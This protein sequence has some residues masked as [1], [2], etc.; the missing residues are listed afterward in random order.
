MQET[1]KRKQIN[2]KDAVEGSVILFIRSNH[3]TLTGQW[4]WDMQ[5][6]ALYGSDVMSFPPDFEGTKGIIHPD[7]LPHVCSALEL[8]SDSE[9]SRLDFRLITTY[10]DVK[11]ICGTNVSFGGPPDTPLPEEQS[12]GEQP[13]QQFALRREVDFLR[14]RHAIATTAEKWLR[15]GAWAINKS[16]AEVWY[17]DGIYHIH[18][19]A[20]QSLNAHAN[21]FHPFLHPDDRMAF[22]DAFE[23]AYKAEVPV[24]L[25]YRIV[26]PDLEI[27]TVRLLTHW[28]YNSKGH[29]VFTA[30]LQDK[31]E[32]AI[33][34]AQAAETESKTRL[35][36][37]V[38]RFSELHWNAGYFFLVP[39]TRKVTYSENY[40]RIYGLKHQSIESHSILNLVHP[41]DRDLVKTFL[42]NMWRGQPLSDI[43][44]R[45]IR[46]DGKERYLKQSG[47]PVDTG[48]GVVL[49][50]IVQD[51]TVQRGLERKIR[52]L[53][54]Q[55]ALHHAIQQLAESI[56]GSGYF[57]HQP[58]AGTH[59]SEGLYRLFGYR[60]DAVVPSVSLLYNHV[61]PADVSAFQEA[62]AAV[63]SGQPQSDCS[64]RFL[65]RNGVQLTTVFFHRIAAANRQTLVGVIKNSAT[66]EDLRQKTANASLYAEVLGQTSSDM[67]LVTDLDNR[68]LHWNKAAAQKTGTKEADAI[69]ANLFD[70]FPALKEKGYLQ[71]LHAAMAGTPVR[72]LKVRNA[73]LRKAH[74]YSLAPL[75]DE[76]GDVTKVLHVVEDVSKE[77]DLQQQLSERLNF[78]E[79]LVDA[80]VDRIVVLDRHMNYLYW[81][82]KAEDYYGLSKSR[83]IGRNIL[84]IFPGFRNDPGYVEFRKVLRGETVYLPATINEESGEYFETYLIPIKEEGNDVSSV[85][86]IVHDLTNE[87]K[88]LQQEQQAKEV[89]E[90]EH[91]RLKEAQAIGRV[92]SF[93]SNIVSGQ[94][95]WSDEMFRIHGL[96]PQCEKMT[97]EKV[98]SFLHPDDEGILEQLIHLRE[99]PGRMDTTHRIV[100]PD[101]DVRMVRRQIQSFAG[102]DG[103]VIYL[104]G[105][106]QDITEQKKAE[107]QIKEQSH[108]LRRITETVPDI[109]S[110]IELETKT[111]IFLNGETLSQHGFDPEKMISI[112]RE[113]R[114]KLI[115]PDDRPILDN[116]FGAFSTA[117][118]DDVV[119]AEYRA[120]TFAGEWKWFFVRGKVFQRDL[121]GSATHVLNVIE[122][123]TQRK[124]AGREL[125]KNL[126]IL[127]QAEELVQMGSWEYEIASGRF[128]WSDGMYKLFGLPQGMAVS[129]EIYWDVAVGEDRSVARR[130]I[131]TLTVDP[132]H[133]EEVMRIQRGNET[134][135]LKI[136]GAVVYDEAGRA[137]RIV[138]VDMDVTDIRVA[139]ERWK[140]S[141]RWLQQTAE[142]SPD[143]IIVYDL[144]KR[145]PVYLNNCLAEW[146]GTTTE[147]LVNRGIDGR[148]EFVHPDDRANLLHFNEKMKAAMDGDLLV[149]EYR[150]L[151]KDSSLLWV[152]NRSK[153]FQRD[154][155][156][157]VTKVLSILQDVTEE[158]AAERVLKALN[159]SLERKN[160][161]LEDKNEEITSFAFVASHDLREPL[162]KLYT[163]SDWLLTKEPSL[164]E[165]GRQHVERITGAVKRLDLLIN[166]ILEL[167]RV[168][169]GNEKVRAVD[170]NNLLQ[171]LREEMAEKWQKAGAVIEIAP[172]PSIAGSE[173]Q[174]FYLFKNLI[175]NAIKFQADG[176][177]PLVQ[178]GAER[179]GAFLK[180]FIRDNGIGIAG[181][182]HK[183][184]FEMFRRLHNRDQ[185]EGTG[186]G[187][188]ICKKI[189]EK[190]GGKITL[191]SEPEKGSTFVCWFPDVSST[192]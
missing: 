186:M 32:D 171:R 188:A 67:I 143:A 192:T 173:S 68:V 35:H 144:A 147:D 30:V 114:G 149:V 7:D 45:I 2:S 77:L 141:Q 133:F 163:Y 72:E 75:Q 105:T 177:E 21:T 108:Y 57:L 191:E 8:L 82:K 26:R 50:G 54:E 96:E 176:Q 43:D 120:E 165:A 172:L 47:K 73:Y 178:I 102:E 3:Y 134:R 74:H 91:L 100:K 156:E 20:P 71:Q 17:S 40:A 164:S 93:E 116:Y 98:L 48:T 158:K 121:Q 62:M 148:L 9:I 185:Y 183:K 95:H 119:T 126:T 38:L 131:Q 33:G 70:L 97:L 124:N 52:E 63:Q 27:L 130:I 169:V 92:G 181:E 4:L 129:P 81:N 127:Q 138:G 56:T 132:R 90:N 111:V 5:S 23:A 36:Q 184:I 84:E 39:E 107:E 166:D 142:A 80:S 125:K 88:L 78:I 51:V 128:I 15:T 103:N 140:E 161:E 22:L 86:W 112:G 145:Q 106:V 189:M 6:A 179:E 65:G 162:R 25:E 89:L 60:P 123:I 94:I 11:F 42:D 61:Y 154:A 159:A 175:S 46:N 53:N 76:N 151:R 85:L 136:K 152:R 18:G 101:G 115:H 110:V 187:L 139:E 170:L 168:H 58:D 153:V 157:K 137:Q 79:S 29:P 174:L 59:W 135:L 146:L 122:D 14:L 118:D 12:P 182:H 180:I 109:I 117:S 41:D 16:T 34:A 104:A 190:H 155:A 24:H 44:F 1:A 13:L 87:Y 31:T 49:V 64:V 150:M 83:V 69:S 66:E 10:G 167:T 55:A 37:Q 99:S 28:T 19:L 113:N 160:A